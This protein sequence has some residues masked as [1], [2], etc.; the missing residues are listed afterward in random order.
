MARTP[1][2]RPRTPAEKYTAPAV[3][4]DAGGPVEIRL[5][6]HR[7]TV[8]RMVAALIAAAG[9]AAGPVSYRPSRYGDGWRAYLTISTP[10]GD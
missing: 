5:I 8:E 6:G 4:P 10:P 9:P 3:S 1:A 2:R 7:A